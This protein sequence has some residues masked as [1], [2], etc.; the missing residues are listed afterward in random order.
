[1]TDPNELSVFEDDPDLPELTTIF[2]KAQ[3]RY[4]LL[5]GALGALLY[6]V[7]FLNQAELW[8]GLGMLILSSYLGWIYVKHNTPQPKIILSQEGIQLLGQPFVSWA[9]VHGL[10]IKPEVKKNVYTENLIFVNNGRIQ[11]IPISQ[12][13][14]TSWRLEHLL[15]IYQGRFRYGSVTILPD[16]EEKPQLSLE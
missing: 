13:D 5:V 12:L 3:D 11:E 4:M 7:Y 10:H 2:T 6:M 8:S 1:M 16:D 15:E 9:L 14:I